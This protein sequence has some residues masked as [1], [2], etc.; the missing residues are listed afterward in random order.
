MSKDKDKEISFDH[1]YKYGFKTDSKSVKQ[2]KR[3]LSE[4]V[5]R[6]IS[7]IKNEPEWMLNTRLNALKAFY[8]IK[9]PDWGPDLSDNGDV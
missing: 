3:G 1:E 9:N 8:E 6:E 4:E 2:T 7:M 5:V